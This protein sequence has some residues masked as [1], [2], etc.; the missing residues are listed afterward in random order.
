VPV[1]KKGPARAPPPA[2]VE[3]TKR[4][5]DEWVAILI[6]FLKVIKKQS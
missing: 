1:K 2:K 6:I 3:F 5:K 4:T